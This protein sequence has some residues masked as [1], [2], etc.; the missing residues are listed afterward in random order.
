MINL[1]FLKLYDAEKQMVCSR[2]VIHSL[3]LPGALPENKKRNIYSPTTTIY[4]HCAGQSLHSK[5]SIKKK[6]KNPDFHVY[7]CKEQL[8]FKYSKY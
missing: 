6:K 3:P 8:N 4:Q 2:P 5:G 1:S 7:C